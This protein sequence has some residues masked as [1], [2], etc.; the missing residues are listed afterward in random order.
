MSSPLWARA[1]PL[2]N[3]VS[4]FGALCVFSAGGLF[5]GNRGGRFHTDADADAA[6]LGIA[7]MDLLRA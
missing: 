5:M 6:S 4:P 7:A 3:R 1:M 2:Q